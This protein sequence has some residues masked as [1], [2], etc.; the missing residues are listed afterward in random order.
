MTSHSDQPAFPTAADNG[1]STNQ[2]GMT[3]RDYFASQALHSMNVLDIEDYRDLCDQ[4]A[5]FA[6]RLAD[7]MMKAKHGH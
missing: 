7:A 3:L 5:V 4:M 1:H 2:D 6:Y